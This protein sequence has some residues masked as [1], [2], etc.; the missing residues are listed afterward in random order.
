MA[1]FFNTAGPV[2]PEA[3]YCLSPLERIRLDEILPLIEQEKYFVLHAPRQAGKT[4]C[5]LALMDYLNTQGQYRCVYINVELA[6]AAREDVAAAMQAILSQLAYQAESVLHD[7]FLPAHWQTIFAQSG[8]HA[9]L[10][11]VLARWAEAS[12]KPLVVLVD[13]ID[14]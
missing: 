10:Y 7:E 9:A 4:S 12:P 13:E 6:Q 11:G 8:A 3:H 5:L 14:A 2:K 1:R